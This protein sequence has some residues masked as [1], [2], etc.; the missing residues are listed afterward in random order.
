MATQNV[1][2]I[3]FCRGSM[4]FDLDITRPYTAAQISR[5]FNV[6]LWTVIYTVTIMWPFYV[7]CT[8]MYKCV[9]IVSTK[10]NNCW[11][12]KISVIDVP[13]GFRGLLQDSLKCKICHISPMKPPIILAKCCRSILGCESCVNRWYEETDALTKLCPGCQGE[14]G[15]AETIRLHGLDDLLSGIREIIQ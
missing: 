10:L 6:S 15:Y 11:T 8:C 4:E 1:T 14:R 13:L 7:H 12:A 9:L 3:A 2:Q 5:M